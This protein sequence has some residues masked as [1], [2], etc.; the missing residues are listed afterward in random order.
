MLLDP[1]LNVD[2]AIT[3]A[4]HAAVGYLHSFGLFGKSAK[5]ALGSAYTEFTARGQLDGVA[6]SREDQG[7]S[8]P[9]AKL[10]IN[11]L[12]SPALDLKEFH[13]YHQNL[14]VGA[15]LGVTAPWGEYDS[16]KAINIGFNRWVIRP[17]L[18][19][20]KSLGRWIVE[21]SASVAFY[22]DNTNF[23]GG[24]TR[25]QDPLTSLQLHAIY[26]IK[27]GKGMWV[28]FDATHFGGGQTSVDGVENDNKLS[29][30]RYGATFAM[31]INRRNSLKFYASNGTNA[32]RGTV[33]ELFGMAWQYRWGGG[34]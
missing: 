7:F 11:F 4:K 14:V 27:P 10:S 32:R 8:D 25:E 24:K 3:R 12:G 31:P 20:S 23:N 22:T 2:D 26:R 16:D 13:N 34:L 21:G 28:A 6:V 33:Y 5:I 15:S 17:E 18:G 30:F 9:V 19:L 1:S 29:N